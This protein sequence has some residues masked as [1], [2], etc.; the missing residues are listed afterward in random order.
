MKLCIYIYEMVILC[1]CIY[2]YIYEMVILYIYIR[3]L[4]RNIVSVVVVLGTNINNHVCYHY[5]HYDFSLLLLLLS[6]CVCIYIYYAF[7]FVYILQMSRDLN[8]LSKVDSNG[9][10]TWK[11]KGMLNSI[12]WLTHWFI[13][14]KNAIPWGYAVS[15]FCESPTVSF[16]EVS[17]KNQHPMHT[18]LHFIGNQRWRNLIWDSIPWIYAYWV[19]G[20][21]Y[22]PCKKQKKST[23]LLP[24][25][26]Q[27]MSEMAGLRDLRQAVEAS[28]Q[29]MCWEANFL[30][31]LARE[32][33][34]Q[35]AHRFGAYQKMCKLNGENGDT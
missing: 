28:V 3:L 27:T 29:P 11:I 14:I 8:H 19:D 24:H 4:L 6:S 30:C 12:H 32:R 20:Y 23:R 5:Y 34:L 10:A 21:L 7:K 33:W 9:F 26:W 2:I 17:C 31:S 25:S 1:V 15:F 22:T 13:Q 35:R 18:P 16:W